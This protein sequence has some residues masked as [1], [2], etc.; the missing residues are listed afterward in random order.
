MNHSVIHAVEKK[1]GQLSV[2]TNY[3]V[4][5]GKTQPAMLTKVKLMQDDEDKDAESE[6]SGD[7]ELFPNLPQVN[8]LKSVT[9]PFLMPFL[10]FILLKWITPVY[11]PNVNSFPYHF[12]KIPLFIITAL[13]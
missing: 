13:L 8:N 10:L 7:E 11:L 3:D 9:S 6:Q 2:D 1:R 12:S 4:N 5:D